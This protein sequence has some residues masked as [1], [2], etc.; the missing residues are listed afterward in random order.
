M[1]LGKTIPTGGKS[2]ALERKGNCVGKAGREA[3]PR[4]GP[5]PPPLVAVS[6]SP[7]P[8]RFPRQ[9]CRSPPGSWT[10]ASRSP[11]ALNA[12]RWWGGPCGSRAAAMTAEERRSL[13]AFRDYVSKILDPTY[14][15]SY[16]A[17]WF[18]EGEWWPGGRVFPWVFYPFS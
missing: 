16:L 1:K 8:L 11:C 12:G 3:A 18:T 4:G 10:S 5:A 2:W 14:V 6:V 15:L 17:P 7:P 9:P 13:H